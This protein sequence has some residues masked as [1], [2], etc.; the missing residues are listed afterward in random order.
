[1]NDRGICYLVKVP[2]PNKR[3]ETVRNAFTQHWCGYF[4]ILQVVISDNGGDVKSIY[5]N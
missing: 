4:G 5:L 1:M 3:A 2:V